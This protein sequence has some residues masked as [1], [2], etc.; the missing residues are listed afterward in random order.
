MK[1]KSVEMATALEDKSIWEGGEEL[2]EEVLRMPT[3]EIVTRSRLRDNEITIM[4]I[5]I[6]IIQVNKTLP[7]LVSHVIELLDM[8]VPEERKGKCAVINISTRQALV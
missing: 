8:V 7:Y 2:G 1:N 3:D 5:K 6:F 4:K